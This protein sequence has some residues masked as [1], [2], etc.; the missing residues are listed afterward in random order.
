MSLVGARTAGRHNGLRRSS[1]VLCEVECLVGVPDVGSA[2]RSEQ[3]ECMKL[4]CMMMND[5]PGADPKRERGIR[6][7]LSFSAMST[8]FADF[9]VHLHEFIPSLSIVWPS[10]S[11]EGIKSFIKSQLLVGSVYPNYS[12]Q[13]RKTSLPNVSVNVPPESGTSCGTRYSIE[14]FSALVHILGPWHLPRTA[15]NF[16]IHQTY[17]DR[18]HHHVCRPSF[19]ARRISSRERHTEQRSR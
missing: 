15:L 18:H 1:H 16:L 12:G 6:V 17:L 14:L 4:E 19:A 3:R 13:T 7:E 10:I 9:S 11:L 8:S 2:K 5:K